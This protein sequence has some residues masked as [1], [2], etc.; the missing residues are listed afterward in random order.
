M[1][2]PKK[3]Q[4]RKKECDAYIRIQQILQC[5]SLPPRRLE[6]RKGNKYRNIICVIYICNIIH[7]FFTYITLH[8]IFIFLLKVYRN[9]I[10]IGFRER[11]KIWAF[12]F[13]EKNASR[14][15]MIV[16]LFHVLVSGASGANGKNKSVNVEIKAN[17]ETERKDQPCVSLWMS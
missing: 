15:N 16:A 2:G 8:T 14:C 1:V 12:Q 11:K 17:C 3:T 10:R 9:F 13:T 4:Q 6:T 7:A 5:P